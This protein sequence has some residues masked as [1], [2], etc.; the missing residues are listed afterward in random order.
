M[1]GGF[2][3]FPAA[4]MS[5]LFSARTFDIPRLM[6]IQCPMYHSPEHTVSA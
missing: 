3:Y 4:T 2:F 6:A 5:V 1:P